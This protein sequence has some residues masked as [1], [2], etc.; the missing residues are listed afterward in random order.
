M[1]L[2]DSKIE[3][4]WLLTTVKELNL[5]RVKSCKIFFIFK[6]ERVK[7]GGSKMFLQ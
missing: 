1:I 3:K 4:Y 2:H 6:E 7:D 5:H